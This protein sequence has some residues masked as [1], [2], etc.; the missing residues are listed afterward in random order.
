MSR[1]NKKGGVGREAER[2]Q[3]KRE[4]EP[5][6]KINKQFLFW[7][8]L[9]NSC[10]TEK[11]PF[12]DLFIF[13]FKL[14]RKVRKTKKKKKT[15]PEFCLK[16]CFLWFWPPI[17][18]PDWLP[19]RILTESTHSTKMSPSSGKRFHQKYS[20]Q[21]YILSLLFK[22]IQ[23]PEGSW[24]SRIR[25]QYGPLVHIIFQFRFQKGSY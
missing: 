15:K 9:R 6:G 13:Y 12:P 3:R 22:L 8:R 16:N 1:R 24:A 17:C 11:L 5:N 14:E 20:V 19:V 23:V 10:S 2:S 18:L 4:E 25:A 21:L 7:L